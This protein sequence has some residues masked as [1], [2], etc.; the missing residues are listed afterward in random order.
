MQA[1]NQCENHDDGLNHTMYGGDYFKECH[2][3]VRNSFAV[4][5]NLIVIRSELYEADVSISFRCR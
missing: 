3:V 2:F 4:K 5:C 1:V